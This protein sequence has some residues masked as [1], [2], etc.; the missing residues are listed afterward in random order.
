M[1]FEWRDG[2]GN[3]VTTFPAVTRLLPVG[4]HTWTFTARDALGAAAS[5]TVTVTVVDTT[6]PTVWFTAPSAGATLYTGF[7]KDIGWELSELGG[8]QRMDVEVSTDGGATYTGICTNITDGAVRVCTWANPGPVSANA[9]LR[10][11]V[12]DN[13]GLAGTSEI[14]IAIAE[15]VLQLD[16]PNT[17]VTWAPGTPQ[18]VRW[19]HNLWPDVNFVVELSRDGGGTWS[20]IANVSNG[21]RELTW[22]V[23]GPR[24][25]GARMRV[26]Q[27]D[28]SFNPNPNLRD[29]SDVDFA[30]D[31]APTASAGGPYSGVRDQAITFDGSGSSDP[32]G[33]ALTYAWSFGDGAPGTGVSPTHAYTSVGTFT[34]TLS[35]NDGIATSAPASA[36]VTIANREPIA[37]A[38]G[39]YTGNRTQPIALDGSGSSD[40]DDDPLTYAWN[41]GDGATGT[42]PSPTHTYAT[43]GP[44]TVTLVVSDGFTSSPP[45]T[46]TVTITNQPPVAN[47]GPDRTVQRR[48]NV[49][50]DGRGSSDPDGT[51][52]AYSWRQVSGPPVTLSGAATSVASF[53]APNQV[54]TLV[55]ELTVTD[56]NGATA[57]D[58]AVMTVVK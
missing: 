31:S 24:T 58:Q 35:V 47:A 32:D 36:T 42:G 39:P 9:R 54:T 51:I 20:R 53:T 33:D 38:G 17:A 49:T 50:L 10:I 45:A 30:I 43:L 41:F 3:L 1:T 7:A 19:T 57:V 16:V 48:S 52:A 21:G 40:P 23:T 11:T 26:S 27:A 6:P 55:F 18:T 2:A 12:R 56:N 22:T 44:F 46:T 37:N 34:V 5:D 8:V 4:T 28:I 29:A 14:P 15:P 13:A 25:A